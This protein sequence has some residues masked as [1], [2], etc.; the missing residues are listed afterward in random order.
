MLT[1]DC[2]GLWANSQDMMLAGCNVE[3]HGDAG[4]LADLGSRETTRW[5]LCRRLRDDR[6]P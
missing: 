1:P 5:W 6:G 4:W 2:L 3:F